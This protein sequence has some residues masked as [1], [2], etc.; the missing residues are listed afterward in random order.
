MIKSILINIFFIIPALFISCTKKGNTTGK[1]IG[2]YYVLDFEN[3]GTKGFTLLK[4]KPET[5]DIVYEFNFLKDGSI[6]VKDLTEFY[7][8]GNGI[9][10]I[11][12]STWKETGSNEYEIDINAE[13]AE[14]DKFRSLA[15]Y[16][17]EE[18]KQEKYLKLQDRKTLK[19]ILSN[20][21]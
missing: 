10:T 15:V 11:N 21:L 6:I 7:D 20:L 13:Y 16:S 14:G 5:M 9:L 3:T 1:I 2:K 12:K 17:L 18:N 8:C 4:T 19:N